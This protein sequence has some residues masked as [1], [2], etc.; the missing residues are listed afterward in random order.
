LSG[1]P[2]KTAISVY[3][4]GRTYNSEEVVGCSY[5]SAHCDY[6]VEQISLF[7]PQLQV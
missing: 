6:S 4:L 2:I 5:S 7:R 1:R 3:Q